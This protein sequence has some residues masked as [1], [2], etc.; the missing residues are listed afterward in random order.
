MAVYFGKP[1]KFTANLSYFGLGIVH[2]IMAVYFFLSR[3]PFDDISEPAGQ[4]VWRAG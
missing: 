1:F 4:L 3:K 2:G